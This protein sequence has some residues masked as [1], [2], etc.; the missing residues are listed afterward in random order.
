MGIYGKVYRVYW[1]VYGGHREDTVGT[2][3][4]IERGYGGKTLEV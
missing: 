4:N 2:C 1:W 3:S